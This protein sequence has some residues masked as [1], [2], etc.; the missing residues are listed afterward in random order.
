MKLFK[1]LIDYEDTNLKVVNI[2]GRRYK[3]DPDFDPSVIVSQSFGLRFDDQSYNQIIAHGIKDSRRFFGRNIPAIVERGFKKCLE[4][5]D[6]EIFFVLE[7]N[8][9]RNL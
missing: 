8:M 7:R 1:N 4:R 2:E 6:E 5:I 3:T 9:T